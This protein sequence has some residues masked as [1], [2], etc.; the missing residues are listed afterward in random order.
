MSDAANTKLKKKSEIAPHEYD[1]LGRL[2]WYG[3]LRSRR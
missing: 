2:H 3:P 1:C